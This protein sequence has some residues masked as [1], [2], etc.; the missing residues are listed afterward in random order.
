[1]A[2]V[3]LQVDKVV[4]ETSKTIKKFL[5]F[6]YRTISVPLFFGR[7]RLLFWTNDNA[8]AKTIVARKEIPAQNDNKATKDPD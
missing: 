7:T 8:N 3:G 5:L 2:A 4:D 6:P 1:M